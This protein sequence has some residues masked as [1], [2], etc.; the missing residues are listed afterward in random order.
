MRPIHDS[1]LRETF[2]RLSSCQLSHSK[3]PPPSGLESSSRQQR[4]KNRSS[5]AGQC[6]GVPDA[7]HSAGSLDK[8]PAK[9]MILKICM[10]M[11][12]AKTAAR[13]R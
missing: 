8:T 4:T 9:P 12:F 10:A 3:Q 11:G 13:S 6:T 7:N 2:D 1:T 5:T